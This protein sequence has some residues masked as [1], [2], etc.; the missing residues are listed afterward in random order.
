MYFGYQ[1]PYINRPSYE[2]RGRRREPWWRQTAALKHL[3]ATLEDISAVARARRWESV[4]CGKG[5]VGGEV[6]DSDSGSKVPW[7]AEMDTCDAQV[8]E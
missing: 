2:G 1:N 5:G 8:V 7:Y 3:S 4:M 6:L